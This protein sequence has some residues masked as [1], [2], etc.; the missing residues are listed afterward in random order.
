MGVALF[1]SLSCEHSISWR[2]YTSRGRESRMRKTTPAVTWHLRSPH[3]EGISSGKEFKLS[4]SWYLCLWFGLGDFY[5]PSMLLF[6]LCFLFGGM[7]DDF[8]LNDCWKL[9]N[10]EIAK[11]K[12][13][14]VNRS[15]DTETAGISLSGLQKLRF[16][17]M[18]MMATIHS[19][20]HNPP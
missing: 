16:C 18:H 11:W 5:F 7:V 15:T 1:C 12:C 8:A 20:R 17:S 2:C 14:K 19:H 13:E 9:I 3:T 10:R 4:S 6:L